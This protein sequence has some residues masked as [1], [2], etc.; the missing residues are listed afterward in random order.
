MKY[1]FLSPHP[2]DVE[3]TCGGTIARLT[4]EGHDVSVAIFSDCDIEGIISEA[5]NALSVL[6]V[7]TIHYFYFSRRMFDS[8]RQLILDTLIDLR[9]KINP[10]VVFVPDQTDIHQDHQVI[11]WEGLRAFKMSADVISYMHPHNQI[12]GKC[13]YFVSLTQD[14]VDLKLKALTCYRSQEHR[15]YFK[16]KAVE[17]VLR[18]YG[19]QVGKEYAEAFKIIRKHEN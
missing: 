4:E 6:N 14:E 11:G 15:F 10:D 3:L 8:S 7:G 12:E 19:V 1:L 16:P 5:S 9:E 17:G 18:Y 2:D 13:N